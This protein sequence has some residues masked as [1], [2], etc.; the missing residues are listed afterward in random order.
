MSL[1]RLKIALSDHNGKSRPFFGALHA[2]GHAFVREGPADLLLIDLDPPYFL[3]KEL[4]DRYTDMGAKVLLYP[5]GGGGPILSYDGLWEPDPR[6]FA[7]LVHGVGHA[8]YLRR[9]GYPSPT[10]V[11]GWSYCPLRPFRATADVKR[12]LFAPTHANGAGT[13]TEHQRKLNTD[14]YRRLLATPFEITVRHIGGLKA[15]GLWK[16]PGVEFVE[17]TLVPAIEDIDRADAVVAADGTFPTL[18]VARGVPTVV[19]DQG[20]VALGTPGTEPIVPKRKHLY[21]DYSRFPLDAAD[22][23]LETLIRTA[24]TSEEPIADWKR[25]FVGDAFD[26]RTFAALIERIVNADPEPARVDPTRG[27][28]TLAFADEL[29]Q[30]P[31]LLQTYA[32]AFGPDDDASLIVWAPGVPA[33]G[34]LRMTER[35]IELAGV[36]ADRLPDIL[37]TPL[38]GSP[39]ADRALSERA[40]AVLTEWPATGLIGKRPRFDAV[41]AALVA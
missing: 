1:R 36:D 25:R 11:I 32:Q 24:A 7:N 21:W 28:T 18:A 30:R 37:L 35:A 27:F 4:I 5:H 9:I 12:V 26:P 20:V 23:D 14:V 39:E 33:D 40:D 17:G 16:A 8:E 3:H 29:L 31:A 38:P 15:N 10:H 41:R 22:G 19:Y 2:A 13:M 6:V 34:L